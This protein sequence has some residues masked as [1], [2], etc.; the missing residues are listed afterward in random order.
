MGRNARSR[1]GTGGSP[2]RGGHSDD[3]TM[4]RGSKRPSD[5]SS[6]DDLRSIAAPLR[7]A[8]RAFPPRLQGSGDVGED[9]QW[10]ADGVVLRTEEPKGPLAEADGAVVPLGKREPGGIGADP[11][12]GDPGR[13]RRGRGLCEHLTRE[14]QPGDRIAASC[15]LDG[16]TSRP[17]SDVEDRAAWRSER[18]SMRKSTS[19]TVLFVQTLSM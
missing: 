3:Q 17:A 1:T 6:F 16:V 8:R 9:R 15:E 18:S 19:A 13:L 11:L 7:T 4:V 10:L 12:D 5:T 14:V 2:S